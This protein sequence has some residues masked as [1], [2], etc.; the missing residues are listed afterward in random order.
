MCSAL[1]EV[2]GHDFTGYKQST[3][4]RRIERRM[5]VLGTKSAQEYLQRVKD[6]EDE[7]D[8]LFRDLLINVTRFFR[9][10]EMFDDLK[11]QVIKPLATRTST[12]GEIRI[13]VPG[14]SSGEEAY[15][16]AILLA[17]AF[18][19][20]AQ[21]PLIQI[22]AT[23]IDESM[24][25]IARE[26]RYPI[27]AL[28]DIPEDL[29]DNYTI[30]RDGFFEISPKVRD[31]VRFSA[32]SL[33]KDPPFSKLDLISCRNLLIYFGDKLQQQVFPIFHYALK[34]DG[35]LFLG[36][37][38]SIGR[39]E[40]LFAVAK[41]KSRIF[42]RREGGPVY[43][44]ELPFTIQSPQKK[45]QAPR[46]FSGSAQTSLDDTLGYR[47]I[48]EHY[49]PATLII[50]A[51][52]AIINS[53]GR[54][55]KYFEFPDASKRSTSA[56][57]LARPGLREAL[58]QLVRQAAQTGKRVVARAVNVKAEFGSQTVDV[59]ADPLADDNILLVFKD[60]APFEAGDDLELAEMGPA[61][62][63]VERLQEALQLTRG[64]LRGT[65]EELETANEEL[66]SSNEEMMSMNEELQ[67]TNE[68]LTTV[69]DELK[70]KVDELVIANSDVRNFFESTKLAVVV[71]DHNMMV[72]T[73]T[74][75]ATDIFPLVR[76]DK[77]RALA[78]VANSLADD[79]HLDDVRK[80]LL[81]GVAES[82]TIMSKS[83]ARQWALNVLPYRLPDGTIDGATIVLND[84]TDILQTK[85][86]LEVERERLKMALRVARIGV[87]EYHADTG[88]TILDEGELEL[89][90][91]TRDETSDI[92]N[93]MALIHEDD[94]AAVETSLRKAI[95]GES[96]YQASFRV[97]RPD[98]TVR[99]L[100][101]LGRLLAG[102]AQKR[103]VGVSFDV[104]P[105]AKLAEQ[106]E[107]MLSEMNHRVKNLF[108]VISGFVVGAARKAKS[109]SQLA[110]DIS[111]RIA[112]LGR[113]HSLTQS[114]TEMSG[115]GL[116][117]VINGAI[118]PYEDQ[119]DISLTGPDVTLH[120][121]KLTPLALILHE[122]ATNSAKYGA[123]GASGGDVEI[124]WGHSPSDGLVLTWR[125]KP[126][127]PQD[128]GD[129]EAG[130]GFGS[131]LIKFSTMQLD[132]SVDIQKEDGLWTGRLA[133]PNEQAG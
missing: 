103:M 133:F 66:K 15:S 65:V 61:D 124:S 118:E 92:E 70:S 106:R 99:H 107:Y 38:E 55:A 49:A 95:S 77:G 2:I 97:N 53:N 87:W 46:R 42:K 56:A 19:G 121:D 111:E 93:L 123:F 8:A 132:G 6:D 35:H 108:A 31:L 122:W 72:R 33:V 54:L 52:G 128:D 18:R 98:G 112:A 83:G 48:I 110:T 36:P 71:L 109:P 105:E 22:L 100:R 115:I 78:N 12:N 28:A 13:W 9:D 17:D 129:I 21:R 84:I 96:D 101:G 113:A 127:L 94:R 102:S 119:A 60:I 51:D 74:D 23:D 5:Q 27:A 85:R 57:S 68:E 75:A 69:N 29:R 7:C 39:H 37:S 3:V 24:L 50:D 30:G 16:I 104:T 114:H 63:E 44:I 26:G 32:H 76:S 20:K 14:C 64:R 43:P 41:Q 62:G 82:R 45:P 120:V 34:P 125:E 131:R 47:R 10:P 25:A 11:E 79:S 86:D 81:G 58:P 59:I 126:R 89:F 80:V 130:T 88:R 1:R 67:S 91:V 40:N 116:A 73:F 4:V 117:D 90:G